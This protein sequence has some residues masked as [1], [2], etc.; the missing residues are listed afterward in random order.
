M[1]ATKAASTLLTPHLI[2][3]IRPP[4]P[5]ITR[6]PTNHLS[7]S[8]T[9]ED[10]KRSVTPEE[11]STQRP[12]ALSLYR[13]LLRASS[14]MPTPNRRNYI[15]NKTRKEY[16]RNKGITDVEEIEFCL[17]LADT[18]LDTVMVQAEHLTRLFNDPEYNCS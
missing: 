14:Q 17:R 5:I 10:N 11:I 1:M 7:T 8:T 2:R 12:R 4:P 18:N 3:R 13:R 6:T 9:T 15:A 16:K